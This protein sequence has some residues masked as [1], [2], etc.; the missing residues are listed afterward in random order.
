MHFRHVRVKSGI[1]G[2]ALLCAQGGR[3]IVGCVARQSERAQP[4]GVLANGMPVCFAF[5]HYIR[6]LAQRLLLLLEK[7]FGSSASLIGIFAQRRNS[8]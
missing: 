1:R 7:R 4:C 3:P 8:F 2:R 5:G 6:A